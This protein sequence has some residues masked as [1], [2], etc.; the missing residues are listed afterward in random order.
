MHSRLKALLPIID[1]SKRGILRREPVIISQ[2]VEEVFSS[3]C[4]K[5]QEGW[6]F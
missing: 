5:A 2:V 3:D 4:S 6:A 1:F